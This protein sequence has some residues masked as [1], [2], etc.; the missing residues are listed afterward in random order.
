MIVA[1]KISSYQH[2]FYL[3]NIRNLARNPLLII[4]NDAL[5]VFKNAI[6]L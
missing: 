6:T 3:L 2:R 1:R 5:D 4:K